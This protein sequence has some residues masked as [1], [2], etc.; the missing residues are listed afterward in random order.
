MQNYIYNQTTRSCDYLKQTFSASCTPFQRT[1]ICSKDGFYCN[2]YTSSCKRYTDEPC[3]EDADC[4]GKSI[5]IQQM[6]TCVIFYL[7]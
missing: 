4:G 3:L 5:C 2:P 7:T 6:C 1:D